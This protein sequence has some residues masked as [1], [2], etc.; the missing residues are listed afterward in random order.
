MPIDFILDDDDDVGG[1]NCNDVA[2]MEQELFLKKLLCKL[3]N[4]CLYSLYY[5]P[6]I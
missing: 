6:V 2:H 1:D 4:F 3:W 5:R